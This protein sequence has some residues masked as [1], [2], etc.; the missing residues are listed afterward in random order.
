[1][2]S[3]A[4]GGAGAS[5]TSAGSTISSKS[6]GKVE[7]S[8]S[9]SSPS[10]TTTTTKASSSPVAKGSSGASK[11]SAKPATSL[12]S[13]SSSGSAS[14]GGGS[15]RSSTVSSRDTNA[16]TPS[17]A[18]SLSESSRNAAASTSAE[19][20]AKTQGRNLRGA[21]GA[22]G[23]IDTP[24]V[25]R[26]L[27]AAEK[28]KLRRQDAFAQEMARTAGAQEADSPA[29]LLDMLRA[30]YEK[31]VERA[32]GAP[33][34]GPVDWAGIGAALFGGQSAAE[35]DAAMAAQR[36]GPDPSRFTPL[37]EENLGLSYGM[38]ADMYMP[39][40]DAESGFIRDPDTG[41][42]Y[43]PDLLPTK[44]TRLAEGSA[45]GLMDAFKPLEGLFD[46]LEATQRQLNGEAPVD[47]QPP[48]RDPRGYASQGI[49]A[50][51][52]P[53]PGQTEGGVID[54]TVPYEGESDEARYARENPVPEPKK[55]TLLDTVVEGGG[56]LLESTP[57]GNAVK[58]LFP[59]IWYGTG[60]AIKGIDDGVS[61]GSGGR[62]PGTNF[63]DTA[64]G[65]SLIEQPVQYAY[66]GLPFP[67][68]NGNGI[69]DR[70]EGLAGFNTPAVN[71]GQRQAQFPNMPP[72][73]P[74]RSNE[75]RYFTGPGY[76]EGGEVE[77]PEM[78]GGMQDPRMSLIADAEDVLEDI[79]EGEPPDA[80]DAEILKAFV[81]QF[82]DDALRA[83][84][85]RVKAG[86][87]M[88]PARSRE[89]SNPRLVEGPGTET[90]DSIPAMIDG[91]QPAALSDGEVVIPADAVRGA[92][93][94]DR[95][96]G[97]AQLMALS[98]MLAAKA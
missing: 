70:L 90:S 21:S 64:N 45:P 52:I 96:K 7:K 93:D 79:V 1:M 88:R 6:T 9:S 26:L 27:D 54:V 18:R 51:A 12:S 17:L 29:G 36:R 68:A 46:S 2:A 49:D 22:G 91:E 16:I 31:R 58:T 60:E 42:Y 39:E 74:G 40:V 98:D 71:W 65:G 10:K 80:E 41:T 57:L 87:K 63:E 92:G 55:K 56:K 19:A 13:S 78:E 30:P 50:M 66:G 44:E 43:R 23:G 34:E 82:G 3:L 33:F 15:T 73:D 89:A 97:A 72:Y 32:G 48:R 62:S 67:D 24:A 38:L 95:E 84:N 11:T 83:L 59:D 5:K 25:R 47:V 28:T 81:A 14:S 35:R 4:S 86:M 69:D 76:A 53:L 85:D 61:Y 37:G 94:G 75:W 8:S 20:K 77:G